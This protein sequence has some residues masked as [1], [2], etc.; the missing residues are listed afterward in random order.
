MSGGHWFSKIGSGSRMKLLNLFL[1]SCLVVSPSVAV[2]S[3]DEDDMRDLPRP[4][5]V[6]LGCVVRAYLSASDGF[7]IQELE[8]DPD[9]ARSLDG[10]ARSLGS[11]PLYQTLLSK[12]KKWNAVPEWDAEAYYRQ[13]LVAERPFVDKFNDEV[14]GKIDSTLDS[15]KKSRRFRQILTQNMLRR[16]EFDGLITLHDIDVDL[17]DYL[18][19]QKEIRD[20]GKGSRAPSE[21]TLRY[22]GGLRLVEEHLSPDEIA[23]AAGEEY[24][25]DLGKRKPAT[26]TR[27][28]LV[29]LEIINKP[30]IQVALSLTIEQVISLR[31]TL[32]SLNR[33]YNER[34]EFDVATF[35]QDAKSVG[36]LMDSWNA[37]IVQR[38]EQILSD[39]QMLRLRQLVFQRHVRDLFIAKALQIT[40]EPYD[41]SVDRGDASNW[42][43][44]EVYYKRQAYQLKRG[45]D[46]FASL[47]GSRKVERLC[48][49]IVLSPSIYRTL[50]RKR[51]T[52]AM[53]QAIRILSEEKLTKPKSNPRREAP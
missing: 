34:K 9:A 8:L 27:L 15:P 3:S 36:E 1:V 23:R 12:T 47:V 26:P 48:G 33:K 13:A 45:F 4:S 22:R 38:L 21:E 14:L 40:G 41:R 37:D 16:G 11:S 25:G 52:E 7:A 2:G 32:D 24:S 5:F 30:P 6:D 18:A 53:N 28:D 31:E 29:P 20:I 19:L 42:V 50:D 46:I 49:K 43:Q 51:D 17:E 10:L 39:D 35:G 44:A